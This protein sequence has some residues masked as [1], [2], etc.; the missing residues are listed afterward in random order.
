MS[1][2]SSTLI[3]F[4]VKEEAQA[5]QRLVTAS[6]GRRI[7]LTGIGKRNAEKAIRASITSERPSL[8]ISSGFAGGLK[9]ELQTCTV[10]FNTDGAPGLVDALTAAGAQPAAFHCADRVATTPEQKAA[11]RKA[12][13]ADAVEM[14]SQ[15]LCS[16]CREHQIPAAIVRVVL[17]TANESLP[18]DFNQLMT[19]DQRL[20][21]AKLSFAI[22]KSPGKIS[23]LMRLQKQ[24]RRAAQELAS[25]LS[26][27]LGSVR[28]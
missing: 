22:L 2:P 11:L 28:A 10:L 13:G 15:I 1:A 17:D 8:V 26:R 23:A 6:S 12:T 16:V 19:P 27:V 5:F 20:D 24:S 3:C 25:V 18:L 9:P 21:P 14:E 4:A 7:L